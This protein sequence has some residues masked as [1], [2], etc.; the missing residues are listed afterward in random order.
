MKNDLQFEKIGI[1][2]NLFI[3]FMP[4][5]SWFYVVIACKTRLGTIA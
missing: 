3:A 4:F 2:F 5:A 1:G